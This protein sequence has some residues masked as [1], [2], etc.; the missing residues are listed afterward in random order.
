ME[1]TLYTLIAQICREEGI[2][3]ADRPLV[4]D[5]ETDRD[6]VAGAARAL[7]VR[8]R[9]VW[10]KPGWWRHDSG[11]LLGFD[12][13]GAPVRLIWEKR[14]YRF[15]D[16]RG[17]GW[18]RLNA[19]TASLLCDRAYV[20]YPG[21]SDNPVEAKHLGYFSKHLVF[22]VLLALLQGTGL[23]LLPLALMRFIDKGPVETAGPFAAV[24]VF[25]LSQGAAV[26]YGYGTGFLTEKI[27][28]ATLSRLQAGL[29][30]RVLKLPLSFFNRN[31][32]RETAALAAGPDRQ[33]LSSAVSGLAAAPL[34]LTVG[35]VL[36]LAISPLTGI[37]A[38]GFLLAAGV[39][40]FFLNRSAAR[41]DSLRMILERENN[42]DAAAMVRGIDHL[43]SLGRIQGL[44]SRWMNRF[45]KAGSLKRP[46]ET[47]RLFDRMAGR[48]FPWV[49]L[50]ALGWE[51]P[52]LSLGEACA[53][54]F[55]V[56]LMA[57]HADRLFQG[58]SGVTALAG[59]RRDADCILLARPETG[60]PAAD[61]PGPMNQRA[62]KIELHQV[63][64]SYG[65]NDSPA[66]QDLTLTIPAGSYTG[67]VGESG[68]GK[69]TLIR[70]L[71]GFER[72][73]RG[74]IRYDGNKTE[75]AEIARL[76]RKMGLVLQ[77]DRLLPGTVLN[78]I[79][80]SA[81]GAS[82]EDAWTAAREAGVD[83]D[84]RAMSMGMSTI[85]DE[86]KLTGSQRQ[87]LLI[88]RALVRHPEILIFDEAFGLMDQALTKRVNAAL[89]RRTATRILVAHRLAAVRD[90]ERILVMKG[91]RI[92]EEGSFARLLEKKGE[93]A[94][95]AADSFSDPG[96]RR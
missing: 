66:C 3:L 62:G 48:L 80:G 20:F 67:I 70:L 85:V 46:R 4:P 83:K 35:L 6:P 65:P 90:C 81:P 27:T 44:K 2:K 14:G 22:L 19:G 68:S 77:N 29:W 61:K 93:F 56:V 17:N 50:L 84:I 31:S 54:L 39:L 43:V 5:E 87:G 74:W 82:L 88:A 75:P 76:R 59:W 55:S 26:L 13:K 73:D 60:H 78:S 28:A 9:R 30:D 94:R 16:P 25:V 69:S 91:G 96:E 64:F 32:A 21:F 45:S 89:K 71:L 42:R 40:S 72:P 1:T 53:A 49:G 57:P 33:V 34:I 58:I 12:R 51:L 92:A 47:A 36:C 10:L 7:G 15:E 52:G 23:C 11:S 18:V 37:A 38:S 86:Q 79:I 8:H 95:L 24:T 41:A 63:S